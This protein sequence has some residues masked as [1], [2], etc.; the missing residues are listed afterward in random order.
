MLQALR[1]VMASVRSSSR[2]PAIDPGPESLHAVYQA[3]GAD[4]GERLELLQQPEAP[5]IDRAA[6]CTM[7]TTDLYA[8][9]LQLPPQEAVRALRHL[10]AAS[11]S[12]QP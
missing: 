12:A 10:F 1:E 8:Q 5:G 9:T 2:E 4:H 6:V 7:V 11:P 3:L